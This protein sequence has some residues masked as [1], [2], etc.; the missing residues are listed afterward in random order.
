MIWVF[1]TIPLRWQTFRW[2]SNTDVNKLHKGCVNARAVVS[3]SLPFLLN[4]VLAKLT[5]NTFNLWGPGEGV[6]TL[7][8]V[9]CASE[10]MNLVVRLSSKRLLNWSQ[11]WGSLAR[12]ET[13]QHRHTQT[14]RERRIAYWPLLIYS[15]STFYK[16]QLYFQ[17]T[18]QTIIYNN[19]YL[20][21]THTDICIHTCRLCAAS[22]SYSWSI[23]GHKLS[24]SQKYTFRLVW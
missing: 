24:L 4:P 14:G 2:K 15:F 20:S 9:M 1:P 17:S 12:N 6:F 5:S 3:G 7:A 10:R 21:H 18:F 13:G 11:T 23:S 8:W 22:S 16:R 19:I